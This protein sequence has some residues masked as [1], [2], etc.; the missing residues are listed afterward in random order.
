LFQGRLQR[1]Y[2]ALARRQGQDDVAVAALQRALEQYR[3]LSYRPGLAATLTEW[4]ELRLDQGAVRGRR[5][6]CGGPW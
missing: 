3:A 1:R 4:G 2:A 6:C 5:R